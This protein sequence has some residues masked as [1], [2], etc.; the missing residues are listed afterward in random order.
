MA[1]GCGGK[2]I[3]W[4]EEGGGQDTGQ[5]IRDLRLRCAFFGRVRCGRG[6]GLWRSWRGRRADGRGLSVMGLS[7]FYGWR[8]KKE[9]GV[10][11][12]LP[13]M[14]VFTGVKATEPS[15]SRE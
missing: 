4:K 2:G 14:S 9:E 15:T 1:E 13:S 7:G 6:I 3:E 8:G 5:A 10:T 11:L 12:M